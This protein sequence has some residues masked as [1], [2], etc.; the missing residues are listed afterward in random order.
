MNIEEIYI[1]LKFKK[2]YKILFNKRIIYKKIKFLY[3]KLFFNLLLIFLLIFYFESIKFK[4]NFDSSFINKIQN[5]EFLAKFS[6]H[7][8]GHIGQKNSFYFLLFFLCCFFFSIFEKK[9][10]RH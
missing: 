2:T 4:K 8:L 1:P 5:S 9:Q 3:L 6:C 10:T 7:N